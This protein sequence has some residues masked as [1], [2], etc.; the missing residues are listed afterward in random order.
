MTLIAGNR[1]RHADSARDARPV[2]LTIDG[3]EVTVPAGTV[4]HARGDAGGHQGARSCA[5]PTA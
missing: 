5:P 2:T 4:D 3:I 1:L